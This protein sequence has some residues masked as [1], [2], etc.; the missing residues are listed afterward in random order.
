MYLFLILIVLLVAFHRPIIR[1]VIRWAGPEFANKVGL[2]LSWQVEGSLWNDFKLSQVEAGGGEGHWLP[3]ATIGELSADYDW[4][5]L[6]KG[7]LEHAIQ[8]VTLHDVDAVADLRKLPTSTEPAL[9]VE[10]VKSEPGPPLLIWP[11]AIDIQ[12]VNADVTLAD[13]SRL[14]IRGLT[15]QMGDGMPG[16]LECAE[17]RREPG[18]PELANLKADVTWGGRQLEIRQLAL[19]QGVILER[20]AVDLR[21]LWELDE[22]VLVTLVARLGEA[23]LNANVAAQGIFKSPMQVQAKVSG[24]QLRAQELKTLGLPKEVDF[25]GGRIELTAEGDP[26]KPIQMIVGVSADVAKIRVAGAQVDR[27]SLQ[28]QVKDGKAIVDAVQVNRTD[29][30]VKLTAEA[31]LPSDIQDIAAAPWTAKVEATLPQVTDFLEQPPPV[32]G[33]LRLSVT[34]QG[35]GATPTKAEGEVNGESL[36]FENYKLPALRTLISMDG[37]RAGVEIPGLELGQGNSLMFKASMTMDDSMPVESS[38]QLRVTDPQKLFETTGLALPPKPIKGTLEFQGQA[39]AKIQEVTAGT[40]DNGLADLRLQINQAS[41]GEGELKKLVVHGAVKNGDLLL[42]TVNVFLDEK[43]RIGL[44][45][46]IELKP[47]FVFQ[48]QGTVGMTELTALNSWMRTFEAPRIQSGAIQGLVEM[49]GQLNPW[50]GQGKVTMSATQVRTEAMPQAMDVTLDTGFSGTTADLQQLEAKLGPWRLLAKGKVTDKEAELAEL[51][52]WQNQTVLMDGTVFAPFDITQKEVSGPEAKPMKISIRAKDLQVDRILADAGIQ[53]IPAGVLNADIQVTGRLDTAQGHVVVDLKEVKVPNAPK[54]FQSAT[55][56]SETVLENKRVKTQTTVSQPPL[57]PLTLEG[58]LPLD[59]VALLES[60]NR[61][62][63]TPLKFSVKLPES[64]LDFVQEYAPDMIRSFPGRAKV[65]MQIEGTLAK[66]VIRG[67]VDIDVKEIAWNQPDLPSVRDLRVKIRADDRRILV[68]DV[69]VLLAGGKVNLNGVVDAAD[70]QNP[71]LDFRVQAR[72]ALVFRDP[73]TSVRANADIS[74]RGTLKQASVN[75]LVE[76]VRGRV[77]K[78]IDLLPV[79]KLPADV[80]PVPPDTSRSE[81]KLTLP[82]LLNDWTFNVNVKTRDPVLIS[83]NLANGA[84]SADALLSGSGAAPQL[85]GGANIDRLLLKLPFSMVKITKGVVTLRPEHPFDPDLDIRGESRIGSNQITLYVYGA[86]TNPKTRFTS[87]PPMSESDIVTLLATGT[88]LNGSAS[89]LASEAATRAAFL[90]LS[91][92]YRKTFNKKKVVRD[93]PPR[94]NMT[95]NPSGADRSSDSVQATYD[96]SDEWRLTGRFTQTG[97]MKLLLGYVLRFGKAAQAMD[98][99][100]ALPMAT[101]TDISPTPA[102]VPSSPVPPAS[103]QGF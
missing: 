28:A 30:Q 88:T 69:S 76:V 84:V 87:T 18:G 6:S 98:P 3:K 23:A 78:E 61:L 33:L 8:R 92:F 27:V 9:S 94:L 26:T 90:F 66:P 43:N 29:N 14:I 41:Y 44:T 38:W 16:K 10:E 50:Q 1:G 19:P 11:K 103:S 65:D 24:N 80:P 89:E 75:G 37:Q 17:F 60:P 59:L 64:E 82:P 73:T 79:L 67:D 36:A 77:F 97:R 53:D 15:L 7:Q 63:E 71:G 100:P 96:L 4:R 35:K 74:A 72:E 70:L 48:T 45:T 86:S 56:H 83:G 31:T 99:R 49:T 20:L 21:Q 22:K 2:P 95:F 32:Q 81:A 93:E 12:N 102:P 55:L 40:Y 47:P 68:Q 39:S 25:D 54:S 34:A 101:N 46:K 62:Q 51:K 52:V 85:T 57:K 42:D 58:D 13:G 5:L 91:E